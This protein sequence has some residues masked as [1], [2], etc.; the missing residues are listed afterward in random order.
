MSLSAQEITARVLTL[1]EQEQQQA[2]DFIEFLQK[3]L[4]REKLT[5]S[6]QAAANSTNQAKPPTEGA[7]ILQIMEDFGLLGCMEGDGELSENYKQHLWD[8]P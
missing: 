1:P 6:S 5:S 3:K 7:K 4:T 2:L 8:K